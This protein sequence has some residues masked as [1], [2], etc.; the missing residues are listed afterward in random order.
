MDKTKKLYDLAVKGMKLSRKHKII[1]NKIGIILQNIHPDLEEHMRDG[2][3]FLDE[4]VDYGEFFTKEDIKKQI[5]QAM[6]ELEE[7]SEPRF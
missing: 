5:E 7:V 6:K 4:M 1:C 3:S 2:Y